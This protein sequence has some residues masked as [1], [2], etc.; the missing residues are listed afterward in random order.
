MGGGVVWI[1]VLMEEV[2]LL[3]L[4]GRWVSIS[5]YSCLGMVETEG[6]AYG[7]VVVVVGVMK[8]EQKAETEVPH[9]GLW[10]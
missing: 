4:L 1:D 8:P 5:P 6:L 2:Y 3:A 10:K 7:I 9:S